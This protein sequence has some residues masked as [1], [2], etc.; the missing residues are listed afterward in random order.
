MKYVQKNKKLSLMAKVRLSIMLTL[1]GVIF[2]S[3]AG[4]GDEALDTSKFVTNQNNNFKLT[5]TISDDIVRKDDTIKLTAL[6]ERLVHKDSVAGTTPK[7]IID[8]IGG[9]IDGHNFSK[10]STTLGYHSIII[11][12][13][14][15]PTSTYEALGFF[16][17]KS[18]S[19]S[20]N[21]T[22]SYDG[23]NISMSIDIVDPR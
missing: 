2:F 16:T 3:I 4:C 14:T 7:L 1:M 5:L 23:I 15:E 17:P 6:V 13:D 9:T 21:V 11:N 10:A 12:I 18:S 22:A 19:S 8:A 20:G